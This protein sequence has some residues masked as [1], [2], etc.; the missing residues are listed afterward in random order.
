M[1]RMTTTLHGYNQAR[2]GRS[3]SGNFF[4]RTKIDAKT[5]RLKTVDVAEKKSIKRFSNASIEDFSASLQTQGPGVY[6]VGLDCHVGFVVNNGVTLRF[7][8]SNYYDPENGVVSEAL[9]G[10]NPLDPK[11]P[12]KRRYRGFIEEQTFTD[13]YKGT[14]FFSY[15]IQNNTDTNLYSFGTELFSRCFITRIKNSFHMNN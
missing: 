2:Y 10:N 5:M 6:I 13:N 8:H 14:S 11:I 12:N 15:L 3:T 1:A 9:N 7:V 4:R